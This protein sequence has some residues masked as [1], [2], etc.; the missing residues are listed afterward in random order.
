M[1]DLKAK[2]LQ[3]GLVTKDQVDKVE[4]EQ[5]RK[6]EQRRAR[7]RGGKR[8]KGGAANAGLDEAERWRKRVAKLAQAP[9]SEQYDVIRG[10]VDRCRLDPA[11][12]LP[13]EEAERFH[14]PKED[15]S[16]GWL[17]LEPPVLEK[18]K[19]GDAGVIAYMSHSGLRFCVVPSDAARDVQVVRP[20]WLRHL[21]GEDGEPVE[22]V[23][24]TPKAASKDGDNDQAALNRPK[25]G[26][27]K[28]G[29]D[30]D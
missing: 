2:L 30:H 28:E 3:A 23:I 24:Q 19:T 6:A 10:W 11:K 4:E 17:T 25:T 26:A 18:L 9:K 14:F 13:S 1:L 7:Q 22:V 27:P 16:I 21:V 15:G 29:A 8:G 12:G 20:Q 5:Q